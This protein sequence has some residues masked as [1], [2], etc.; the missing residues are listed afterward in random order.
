MN[1]HI[2]IPQKMLDIPGNIVVSPYLETDSGEKI[3]NVSILSMERYGGLESIATEATILIRGKNAVMIS[4]W[5]D[6]L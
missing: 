4:A 5:K 3:D 1:V 6:K 2:V